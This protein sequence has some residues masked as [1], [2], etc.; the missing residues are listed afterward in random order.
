MATDTS[1]KTQNQTESN[2]GKRLRNFLIVLVGVAL[3]VTLVVGLRTQTNSVSLTDLDERSTPLE[4]AL[5]NGKPSLVEFYA[6]WCTVC[7]K[8]APDIAALETQYA[9][10]ANFVML[11]VD[12]TKWLPEMLRYRVD[13][14]PHFVFLGQDGEAIAETIGEQP[15]TIMASN[16]DALVTGKTLPYAET[17]GAVSEFSTPVA[18]TGSQNDP[19]NHGNSGKKG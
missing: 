7:Q 19:R 6:N 5:T 15:R 16:L 12:N 2:V 17:K 13:G 4:I 14:I 3:S 1:V 18:P 11:N 9:D 10:R 8:M